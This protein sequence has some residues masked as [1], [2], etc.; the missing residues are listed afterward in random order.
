EGV[1]RSPCHLA[2]SWH[3]LPAVGRV[4]PTIRRRAEEDRLV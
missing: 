1:R 2:P 3:W 4:R